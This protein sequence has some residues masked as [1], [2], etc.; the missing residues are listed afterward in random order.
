MGESDLI[1]LGE[2]SSS[3]SDDCPSDD[4][5]KPS[6]IKKLIPTLSNRNANM[7]KNL[8]NKNHLNNNLTKKQ[9]SFIHL[10]GQKEKQKNLS[11]FQLPQIESKIKKEINMKLA[12]KTAEKL[13]RE[14]KPKEEIKKEE[15]PIKP[16]TADKAT[17]TELL[18]FQRAQ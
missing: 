6:I 15:I 16:I 8:I 17:K 10:V 7:L 14:V 12:I 4:N 18:D 11:K 3:G 5:L 13:K 1:E 9:E 2:E